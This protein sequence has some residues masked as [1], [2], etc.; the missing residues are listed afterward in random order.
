MYGIMKEYGLWSS[1]SVTTAKYNT[2]QWATRSGDG[3]F[4]H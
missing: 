2:R 1:Q 3:H 4:M